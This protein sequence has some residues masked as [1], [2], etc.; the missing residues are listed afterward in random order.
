VSEPLTVLAPVAGRV[1]A[2]ADVPDPVFAGCMVGPGLAIDPDSVGGPAV[3]VAPIAGRIHK[4]HPHAYVVVSESGRGV[5]VHL[6][7]DT[8]QL[9]GEGFRLLASEKD[10]VKAGTPVVEWNPA[11][12][13]AGGRSAVCPVVALDGDAADVRALA[14]DGH[15]DSGA[16]LYAWDNR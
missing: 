15:I 11:D 2:M 9:K 14:G 8:V 3:A 10:E 1:L 6:G 5:L 13:T 7:I 16:E 4:L 12:I